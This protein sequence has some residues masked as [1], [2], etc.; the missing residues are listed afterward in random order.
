[1]LTFQMQYNRKQGTK[2]RQE[3]KQQQQKFEA[4]FRS[5]SVLHFSVP[6]F[7]GKEPYGSH[8]PCMGIQTSVEV[9]GVVRLGDPVYVIYK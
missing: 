2:S 6:R 9:A 5:Y 1:M 8:Q 3:K 7:R 4:H